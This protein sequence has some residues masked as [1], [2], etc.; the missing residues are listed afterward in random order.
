M[1]TKVRCCEAFQLF[2]DF[3]FFC[4]GFSVLAAFI[5][6]KQLNFIDP[7]LTLGEAC[8]ES[9]S[10]GFINVIIVWGTSLG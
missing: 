6:A 4:V 1:Y 8:L 9:D 5:I 10:A 7:R 3:A 2:T